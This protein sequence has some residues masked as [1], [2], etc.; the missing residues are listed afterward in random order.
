MKMKNFAK[1]TLA[2]LVLAVSSNVMADDDIDITAYA[3]TA[4]QTQ[5]GFL[6]EQDMKL[7]VVSIGAIEEMDGDITIAA[8]YNRLTQRQT[9]FGNDQSMSVATVG[10]DC[11]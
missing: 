5:S 1:I 3:N 9:G 2:S 8:N 10:C 11:N 7:A 4:N 6:N